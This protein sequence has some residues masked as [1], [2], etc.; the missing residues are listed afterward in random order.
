MFAVT[1]VPLE[2]QNNVHHK[3]YGV[4]VA[5]ARIEYRTAKSEK[6]PF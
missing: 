5:V 3:F 4:S 1:E 2:S 6:L